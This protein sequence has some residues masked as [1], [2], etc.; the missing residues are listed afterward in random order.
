MSMSREPMP[1]EMGSMAREA[2]ARMGER[3]HEMTEEARR[4]AEGM[5]EN[6]AGGMHRA[7][8]R[9]R[10]RSQQMERPGMGNRIADPLDRGAMYLQSHTW[11][12]IRGDAMQ[13]AREHP[14]WVAAGVFAA[15]FLLGRALRRR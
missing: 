5:R 6:I 13:T 2:Q 3:T 8:Q 11:N 12:Q 10:E 14:G 1:G 9:L 15:A 4:R 7:A